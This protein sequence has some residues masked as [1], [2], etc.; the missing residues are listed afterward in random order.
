VASSNFVTLELK[1]NPD[2][3]LGS[4]IYSTGDFPSGWVIPEYTIEQQKDINIITGTGTTIANYTGGVKTLVD[5]F[6]TGS[7][8]NAEDNITLTF[9]DYTP[10]KDNKKNPLIIWLHG[11]GEGGT[12]PTIP[13]SGNKMNILDTLHGYMY[14]TIN[15][16]VQ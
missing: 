8:T 12:D 5:D 13:I 10:A 16:R 11:M 9:A 3:Y 4:V 15:A 7:F 1:I 2:D 14:I 6:E